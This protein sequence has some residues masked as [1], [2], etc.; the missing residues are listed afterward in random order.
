MSNY[1]AHNTLTHPRLAKLRAIAGGVI[2]TVQ[3]AQQQSAALAA[4]KEANA[5]AAAAGE[6]T[7]VGAGASVLKGT[8]LFTAPK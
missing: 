8:T 6:V 2:P 7:P 4:Q 1:S 3:Q 5:A